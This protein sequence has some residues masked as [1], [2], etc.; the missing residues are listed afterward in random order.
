TAM[1]C[2]PTTNNETK[3][4]NNS[5]LKCAP[6][7][8]RSLVSIILSLVS[9]NDHVLTDTTNNETKATKN[10]GLKWSPQALRPLVSC[11]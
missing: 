1:G 3:D 8:L 7:A 4:A 11:L 2:K 6:Q 10:S 5:G 9:Y